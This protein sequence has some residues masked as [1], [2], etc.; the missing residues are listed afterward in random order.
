M[1]ALSVT[2]QTVFN[3]SFKSANSKKVVLLKFINKYYFLYHH[4]ISIIDG[5]KFKR[6]GNLKQ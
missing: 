1:D 4:T 3:N 2:K 5:R 6:K